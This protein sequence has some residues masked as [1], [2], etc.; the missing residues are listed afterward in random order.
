MIKAD[1]YRQ[2]RTLLAEGIIP[3]WLTH[4][5]DKEYGGVLSCM[6]EDGAVLSDD[7]YVW[8]QARFVWTLAALYNR[9]EARPEFLVRS[10]SAID[11]LVANARDVN[12]AYR[13][14]RDGRVL[15]GPISIY[16]D[17][18]VVYGISEYCR[19]MPD[20]R[21]LKLARETFKIICRRVEEPDFH[22][23][24]PYQLLPDRRNHGVPM[25]LT[26]VANELAQTTGDPDVESAADEYASRVMN[27]FVR[28]ERKLLLEFLTRNY[29]ELPPHEGTFVMPGH[30]IESMWFVLH[31]AHRR[32]DREMIRRASE[33]MRW[34]LEVAGMRSLRSVPWH[35]RQAEHRS[36]RIPTKSSGGRIRRRSGLLLAHELTGQ[37]WC[38]EW[39]QR[40]HDWSRSFSNA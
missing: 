34:H 8:S 11:F 10:R 40:V 27:R 18:F 2:Y 35:R 29:E 26:E 6:Q 30:A 28:P 16:S 36:C 23:T 14:A 5:V 9:F 22:E 19:A 3:F 21:L 33:V 38:S 13:L 32:G 17:C 31:W 37:A 20:E 25:I 7:K 1:L 15:E 24:A 4:G 12:G 39:Y